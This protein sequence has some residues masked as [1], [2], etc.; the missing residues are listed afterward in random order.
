[1][2]ALPESIF[3]IGYLIFAIVSGILLVSSKGRR[4]V[5]LMGV[6]ALILGCGDAFHLIPRV[7][8]YW[9]PEDFTRALGIGKL[10]TSITMTVFYVLL[11]Y[12][13]TNRFGAKKDGIQTST[14]IIWVLAAIRIALCLFP[15]NEWTEAD[16]PVSWGIYRNIPFLVIGIMTVVLWYKDAKGDARFRFMALA[17]ALSFAFYLPV[18][19]LAHSI[20][21]MGMLM[22][23]KTVM[24][25]WILC[26]FLQVRKKEY[27]CYN[28]D[29]KDQQLYG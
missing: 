4:G 26:M 19:V 20:P 3:D 22:L 5:R 29:D 21:I 23:P 25:I 6:A 7:F 1:M 8:A 15:Q 11:E 2:P 12:I 13:R 18:V 16:A 27:L 10:V 28:D 14:K 17:V 24:Y 9:I